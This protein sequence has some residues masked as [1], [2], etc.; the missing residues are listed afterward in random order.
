MNFGVG[1]AVFKTLDQVQRM[2]PSSGISEHAE[3]YSYV[4]LYLFIVNLNPTFCT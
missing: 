3:S 4:S 1:L 2:Y